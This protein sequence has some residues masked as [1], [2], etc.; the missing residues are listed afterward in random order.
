MKQLL[1]ISI[2]SALIVINVWQWWPEITNNTV[3]PGNNPD[4]L[5]ILSIPLPDY[6][7]NTQSRT[8]VN[9]FYGN[10]S[11]V[12]ENKPEAVNKKRVS[13]NR[14]PFKNYLLVGILYK[15]RR[16]NAF[17]VIS[18]KNRMV[19][20]GD[21]I[22]GEVRIERITENSVTLKHLRNNKR[23]TIKLQ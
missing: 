21:V 13:V 10:Q 23:R 4:K 11:K 22:N 14:D 2:I 8:M 7:R 5:S 15:N 19:K 20:K 3:E 9:P 17:M 6:S 12:K 18:G 1:I 16:M